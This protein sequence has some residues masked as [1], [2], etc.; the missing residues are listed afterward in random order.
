MFK[1]IKTW[2]IITHF[3]K[4]YIYKSPIRHCIQYCRYIWS[5]VPVVY[6]EIL[7]FQSSSSALLFLPAEVDEM[8]T[9]L[10]LFC[11]ACLILISSSWQSIW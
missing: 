11:R 1:L 2:L 5:G 6:L 4:F 9:G 3:V 8:F 7:V 10:L